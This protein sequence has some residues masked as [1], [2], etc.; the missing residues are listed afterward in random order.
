M[1]ATLPRKELQA[2]CKKHGIKA[3]Q[4]TSVLVE[5]LQSVI[6]EESASETP[7]KAADQRPVEASAPVDLK[8]E[9]EA[10]SRRE[11]QDLCKEHG[12]KASGKTVSLVERLLERMV[13]LSRANPPRCRHAR[14][15]PVLSDAANPRRR[16]LNLVYSVHTR[17][18][19]RL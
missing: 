8:A 16:W 2:L 10:K 6:G 14:R 3:N 9:L 11:L 4:K 17:A 12:L 19:G 5:A 15:D 1:L 18:G 13:R 7:A